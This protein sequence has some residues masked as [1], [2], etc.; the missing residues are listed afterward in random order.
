M[1]PKTTDFISPELQEA[2]K[3]ITC[4]HVIKQ[5]QL[6]KYGDK[7]MTAAMSRLACAR[8]EKV[9]AE[10]LDC[11]ATVLERCELTGSFYNAV[12]F[13]AK[14][15]AYAKQNKANKLLSDSNMG[16][17]FQQRTFAN[18]AVTAQNKQAYEFCRRYVD[19][20]TPESK[21]ILLCGNYG[22]G[23]THL[24]AAILH[25]LIKK[26]VVCVFVV[27]PDLLRAIREGYDT[28][29]KGQLFDIVRK[30]EFLVLDD[31]GAERIV[32]KDSERVSWSEEQ[33]YMLLNYRYENMLPTVIT[34]N[35]KIGELTGVIGGR[36]ASRLW[37][38]VDGIKLEGS[39]YRKQRQATQ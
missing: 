39:D 15:L 38:M 27:M 7:V 25:E 5:E 28:G 9:G 36:I 3:A 2:I 16:K 26:N 17:R 19:E 23:K 35:Y 37:E 34:S 29:Q 22:T 33:L 31:I 4:E 8:C 24:A 20:Y 13:C 21:G 10:T 6:D 14:R 1:R 18:F 11:V 32:K 12:S 30:A